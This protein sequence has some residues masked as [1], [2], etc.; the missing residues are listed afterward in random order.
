MEK[1]GQIMIVIHKR[2]SSYL[3]Y[4][5]KFKLVQGDLISFQIIGED[6]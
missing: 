4:N 2:T 1:W 5:N 3:F 6:K